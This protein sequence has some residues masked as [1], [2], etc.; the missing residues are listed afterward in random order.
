M[1]LRARLYCKYCYTTHANWH[2]MAEKDYGKTVVLC[3]R[4]EHTSV[5]M[6]IFNVNESQYAL[7]IVRNEPPCDCGPFGIIG[8]NEATG[9]V[10]VLSASFRRWLLDQVKRNDPV[11]DLA[12]DFARDCR[13]KWRRKLPPLPKL[14]TP[15]SLRPYLRNRGA[16]E[17]ALAAL[18]KAEREWRKEEIE[19]SGMKYL[20]HVDP[21]GADAPMQPLQPQVA[22]PDLDRAEAVPGVLQQVVE[23]TARPQDPARETSREAHMNRASAGLELP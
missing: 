12:K 9:K 16:C 15:E 21:Q 2:V 4:C 23:Q 3:E 22:A 11:G 20:R 17:G 18:T 13:K 8:F 7:R 10:E 1:E 6:L 14:I 5:L 19:T